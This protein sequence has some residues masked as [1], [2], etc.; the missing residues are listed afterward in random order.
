MDWKTNYGGSLLSEL[1]VKIVR[2]ESV[3]RH[4]D[5]NKL[6]IVQVAGWQVVVGK[7]TYRVGDRAAYFPPDTLIP[8][9]YT[10]EWGVTKYCGASST[11]PQ[12]RDD[13]GDPLVRVRCARLRGEPSFGLLAPAP[14]LIEGSSL[15]AEYFDARKYHPPVKLTTGDAEADHPLFVQYTDIE[16]LRNDPDMFESGEMVYVATKIDGTNSRIGI[17]EEVAMAG[18]HRLRRK[19]PGDNNLAANTY[20]F[21]WSIPQVKDLLLHLAA[22]SKQVIIYGEIH[23]PGIQANPCHIDDLDYRVFDIYVDGRYLDWVEAK[24][25]CLV[26]NVNVVAHDLVQYS[27]PLIRQ[28]AQGPTYTGKGTQEG[29]VIRPLSERR[30]PKYGRLIAKYLADETLLDLKRVDVTDA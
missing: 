28:L 11:D 24:T 13:E 27:L 12:F 3:I 2:I 26:Y 22:D 8:Q 9:H 30:H 18:S 4:P 5:A 6:D 25:L 10:D 7:D 14:E 16:N 23:G 21:P 15:L 29:V 20:W 19:Y 17:I 1:V